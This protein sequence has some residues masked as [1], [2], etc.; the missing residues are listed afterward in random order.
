MAEIPRFNTNG[1]F[2]WGH[3]KQYI[4]QN[5][6]IENEEELQHRIDEALG[7]ITNEMIRN[8][9]RNLLIR[10][11]LCLQSNGGHFEQLL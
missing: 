6:S 3:L 4:Y 1:L 8:S 10:T 2:F 5:E 11:Q 7:K 9:G